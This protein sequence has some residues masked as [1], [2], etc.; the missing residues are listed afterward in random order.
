M[1]F[2][3]SAIIIQTITTH[4]HIHIYIHPHTHNQSI[5]DNDNQQ[6]QQQQPTAKIGDDRKYN[7]T[8][9]RVCVCVWLWV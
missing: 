2:R 7:D 1:L 4:T 8:I 6:Q 9:R 5:N 3:Q